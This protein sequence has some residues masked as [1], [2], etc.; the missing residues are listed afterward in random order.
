MTEQRIGIIDIGS[1]SIRLAIYERTSE[2]AYR[3]IDGSKR[4]GRL[5]GQIDAAGNM[6]EDAVTGLVRTL[7]HFR[8]I[9]AHQRAERIRAVATAAIR[10]ARNCS[11]ILARLERETGLP[12]ELLSG[13]QEAAYGFLGMINTLPVEHGFLIDI[14][15]GSTE[16]SLF[17]GR[18]LVRSVS[19]PFGS[20]TMAKLFTESGE[21]GDDGLAKLEAL[22]LEAAAGESWIRSAP[23]L[24][25][26]GVGGTVRALG[27][28]HQ[29]AVKYPLPDPHNYSLSGAETDDLF[30]RLRRLPLDKRRKVPGLSK[31]RADLIVPGLAILRVL[32]RACRSSSCVVCGAGLR[33][34]LFFDS[35]LG[36]GGRLDDVLDYSIGNL[37]ALYPD[38]PRA[39]VRQVNRLALTL[40]DALAAD[41]YF[42]GRARVWVDTASRLF[43]IGASID[44]YQYAKHTFYLMLSGRLNGLPHRELILAAA[45]ASYKNRSG[46]RQLQQRYRPVLEEDDAA[47]IVKLGTLLQLAIALDR[48]EAQAIS[49]LSPVRSGARLLLKPQ[50]AVGTLELERR[51]VEAMADDFRKAWGLTPVLDTADGAY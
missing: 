46:A 40:Y 25:L 15:G 51:E 21:L 29:A 39:H 2:G 49:R 44:Y 12:V 16:L 5:G 30:G 7:N 8:L 14:G 38:A 4:A 48:S 11:G 9:C 13:E 41:R 1:N 45:I 22:V 33:D 24:P 31:D 6:N 27:K 47:L 37:N 28:I 35:V 43:R 19:F 18:E 10:N 17:R 42:P 34:G 20:V 3:V 32:F 23:G 36:G 50:E 26:V